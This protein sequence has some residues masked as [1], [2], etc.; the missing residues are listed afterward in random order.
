[1][2]FLGL[3]TFV[4]FFPESRRRR[5]PVLFPFGGLGVGV[6]D[7]LLRLPRQ[8]FNADGGLAAAWRRTGGGPRFR[9][10]L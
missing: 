9:R 3:S 4:M 5:V 1:M 10:Y 2:F 6:P 7:W 8:D